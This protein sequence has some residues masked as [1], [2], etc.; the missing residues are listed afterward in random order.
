MGLFDKV[1]IPPEHLA[2]AQQTNVKH[3]LRVKDFL[4]FKSSYLETQTPN[5]SF[6]IAPSKTLSP[7]LTNAVGFPTAEVGPDLRGQGA[8][9]CVMLCERYTGD[10]LRPM[11]RSSPYWR[12][13]LKAFSD[14]CSRN[15]VEQLCHE[16]AGGGGGGHP[17]WGTLLFRAG[18]WGLGLQS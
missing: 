12:N 7:S 5:G 9:V 14:D 4:F 10:P 6:Q 16:L 3:F 8:S 11:F 13:L 1:Y 2:C 17:E 15:P 18:C